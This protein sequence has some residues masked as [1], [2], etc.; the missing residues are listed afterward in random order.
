[1]A[2]VQSI[3]ESDVLALVRRYI[4]TLVSCEIRKTQVNRV[5]MP[6][7]EFV[8]LSP[9]TVSKR[10]STNVHS[11]AG[12][13]VDVM[14]PCQISVQ[15]DCYGPG[16]DVKAQTISTLFWD[17][18]ACQIFKESEFDIQPL[19]A[20]DPQQ[21]PLVN[22]E[23]QY[24]QRWTL[25]LEMQA[26]YRFTASTSPAD[27]SAEYMATAGM[28]AIGTPPIDQEIGTVYVNGDGINKVD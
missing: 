13:V 8:A 7:G 28:L 19:Y 25:K 5:A 14:A 16:S 24:E 2:F 15:V 18:Y 12:T 20:S 3:T 22:G 1:M 9:V 11:L 26:N 10:L 21:I 17:D 4:K 23:E 6:K 27:P